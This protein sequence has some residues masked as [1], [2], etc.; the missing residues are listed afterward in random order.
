MTSCS[1]LEFNYLERVNHW[2]YFLAIGKLHTGYARNFGKYYNKSK[3]LFDRMSLINQALT[4]RL[5]RNVYRKRH[6]S[7]GAGG[8]HGE[9]G[10]VYFC[11]AFDCEETWLDV[12]NRKRIPKDNKF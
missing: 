4:T 9:C 7:S 1:T 11:E 3:E 6:V 8:R 2:D 5:K 12:R 10:G